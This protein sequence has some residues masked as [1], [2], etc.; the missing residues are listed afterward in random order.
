MREQDD[1][2][3]DIIREMR[4][5]KGRTGGYNESRFSERVEVLGPSVSLEAIRASITA[6]CLDSIGVPWDERFGELLAY[7]GKHG[8]ADVSSVPRTGLASWI[9]NQR[10]YFKSN[11]MQSDRLIRLQEIG[12]V[13]DVLDA[14]WND[15]F[16]ELLAYGQKHGNLD[17]PQRYSG[18]LGAWVNNQ[19]Q[20]E[21]TGEMPFDKKARLDNSGFIWDP[22][23]WSWQEQYRQ[24][25]AYRHEHGT[26]TD[27]WPEDFNGWMS[28]QRKRKEKGT[29]SNEKLAKLEAIGFVWSFRDS[30]W[31]E[32]VEGLCAYIEKHGN[33]DV[34]QREPSG[35]GAWLNTR[36]KEEK[37]GNL[38]H[39]KKAILEE[40]GVQWN[41]V[42]DEWSSMYEQL[43]AYRD[44]NG[45]TNVPINGTTDLD[46]W[47]GRQR[48][49]KKNKT[50]SQDRI[51]LLDDAGF[52]WDPFAS[53][54]ETMFKELLAYR[55]ENRHVNVPQR[56]LTS[57][58]RWVRV[59]R[60]SLKNGR[61]TS[62]HKFRLDEIGFVWDMRSNKS[63]KTIGEN[64]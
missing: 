20:L 14:Q 12:F 42:G 56:P 3:V 55:L 64:V 49:A 24:L 57:L 19:R 61:L 16:S 46:A 27:N 35:L 13:W 34:P 58:G 7:K 23:E 39:E 6:E 18:G 53:Q 32:R 1:V 28:S 41:P 47:V 10:T 22:L 8:N 17:I 5:D 60:E 2:L 44:D 25:F 59:Q 21:K 40:M 48:K 26:A 52:D 31:Q 62:E 11:T 29:L 43:L 63:A 37:S 45:T 30:V 51:S 15:R 54:W 9:S 36:R 33:A 38:S 50:L 4:E